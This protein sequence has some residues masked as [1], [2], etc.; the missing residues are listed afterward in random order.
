MLSQ[1]DNELLTRVG[2]GT[3]MGSL[4]RQ[5]W[6]PIMLSS[7]VPEPDCKPLRVKLLGEDLIAFR[8]ADG[9]V[10]LVEEHCAHRGASLYFARNE[11]GGLRC[12][13]HGWMYDVSGRCVDMPNEPAWSNFKDKVSITAYA[14][15]ERNGL[16]WAYMGPRKDP[17]PLPDLEFNLIP[18]EHVLLWKH[19]QESNW[20]QGLEGNIDSSHLSFLHARLDADG[21][22]GFPGRGLFLGVREGA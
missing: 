2:P 1:E 3:V 11:H 6:L 5:Y 21:S 15:R 14:C 16:V 9:R 20:V 7:E 22:A 17:P 19:L 10:G 18:P 4:M 13:Y 8:D 12:V